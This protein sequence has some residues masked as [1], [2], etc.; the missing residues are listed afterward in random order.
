MFKQY[1]FNSAITKT[2]SIQRCLQCI[3][4]SQLSCHS[5]AQQ[6]LPQIDGTPAQATP[7]AT[8]TLSQLYYD[9]KYLRVA[10][11]G[12]ALLLREPWNHELRL[13]VANSL[14]WTGQDDEAVIQYE[15]LLHTELADQAATGIANIKRWAGHPEQAAPYYQQALQ[16]NPLNQDASDGAILTERSLRPKTTFGVNG[17][18][19][20][21]STENHT[22]F[23]KQ[24]WR[25]A[26][27]QQSFEA[28]ANGGTIERPALREKQAELDF[29]YANTGWP[30]EPHAEITVQSTPKTQLF[31]T[32]SLTL[33]GTPL[34]LDAGYVNWGKLV[35]NPYALQANLTATQLGGSMN[36]ASGIGRVRANY[37]SYITS[38]DNLVQ[39]FKI[40][41]VPLWQPFT[42][43]DIKAFV[44]FEGHKARNYTPL[45]WS[46]VTG[47][48]SLTVGISAEWMST[49]W[50]NYINAQYG[51]PLGGEAMQSWSLSAGSKRQI[52]SDWAIGIDLSALS[53]QKDGAY[54]S[55]GITLQIEKLW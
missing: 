53:S 47:N 2:A 49:S 11:E 32:L 50:Q 17:N 9:G 45:Y 27:G 19:D 35:F 4:L 28:E 41:Y 37:Q 29:R 43:P 26:S 36:W 30:M 13:Q 38:D 6:K 21:D 15:T 52:G 10:R 46:P 23:L 39:D 33:S 51:F 55:N 25:D 12:K 3:L 31:G 16:S 48:Y 5:Y 40:Q 18:H 54:K 42:T 24:S 44:G 22:V 1:I 8:D 20:S 7:A 34:S 14:A